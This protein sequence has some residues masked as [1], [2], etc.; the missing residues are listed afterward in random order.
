MP[1]PWFRLYSRIVTDPKIELLSFEDQRHFVWLLC[2]K[3]EGYLD[4]KFPSSEMRDRIIARKLGVGE[5]SLPG[6]KKRLMDLGLIN[7]TFQPKNW[8]SLQFKSD[9][10]KERVRKYRERQRKKKE[11]QGC[12][13]T[14]TAQDTET[15]TEQKKNTH[16]GRCPDDFEPD[17][18]SLAGFK[19]EVIEFQ[20][21]RFR[22]HRFNREIDNWQ[23]EWVKWLDL[24]WSQIPGQGQNRLPAAPA[25]NREPEENSAAFKRLQELADARMR[26]LLEGKH[27]SPTLGSLPLDV[28][29]LVDRVYAS[30][31]QQVPDDPGQVAWGTLVFALRRAYHKAGAEQK[32]GE[33]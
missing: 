26:A 15:D 24:A 5:E 30:A 3:N 14:E 19:P 22:N 9:S 33:G 12:N 2:L 11:Q 4:E 21:K 18:E 20:L 7:S 29:G 25:V 17:T 23:H 10:S 13:V 8:D 27:P 16:T 32:A 31:S 6:I 28:D 1:N